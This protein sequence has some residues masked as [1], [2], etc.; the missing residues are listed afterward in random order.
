M[1]AA[2]AAKAATDDAVNFLDP[3]T[4]PID[5][6]L[7]VV[8]DDST[9]APRDL[10]LAGVT[11]AAAPALPPDPSDTYAPVPFAHVAGC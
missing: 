1:A 11:V 4:I 7:A 6:A 9:K 2:A 3:V 8:L 10:G 5:V